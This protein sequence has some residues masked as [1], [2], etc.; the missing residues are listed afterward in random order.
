[1]QSESRTVTV[2][3][4]AVGSGPAHDGGAHVIAE[5]AVVL[6]VQQ[7]AQRERSE[8]NGPSGVSGHLMGDLVHTA[9]RTQGARKLILRIIV[10]LRH[11]TH[12]GHPASTIHNLWVVDVSFT[13]SEQSVVEEEEDEEGNGD[14]GESRNDGLEL[15]R[16][17]ASV[18]RVFR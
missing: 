3:L 15:Q 11:L 18:R 14:Q 1:M 12:H 6:V 5:S 8:R 7:V 17:A 10:P 13:S 4:A 9:E 16:P 2:Q